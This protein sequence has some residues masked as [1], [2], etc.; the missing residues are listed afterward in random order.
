MAIGGSPKPIIG[1]ASSEDGKAIKVSSRGTRAQINAGLNLGNAMAYA[2]KASGGVGGGHKIAA[3]ANIPAENL[4]IFL[5]SLAEF[6]RQK[7]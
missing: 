6:L 4:N 3:G 1:I 2:V 5:T 7:P